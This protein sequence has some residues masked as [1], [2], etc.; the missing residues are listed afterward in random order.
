MIFVYVLPLFR[1]L[2]QQ[3]YSNAL[4]ISIICSQYVNY[5]A[6]IKL[7]P[8]SMFCTKESLKEKVSNDTKRLL[9]VLIAAETTFFRSVVD[10]QNKSQAPIKTRQLNSK[11]PAKTRSN[12]RTVGICIS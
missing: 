10:H 1:A 9:K 12:R 6:F 11:Q 2:Y 5:F 7:F 8:K 3:S 4:N